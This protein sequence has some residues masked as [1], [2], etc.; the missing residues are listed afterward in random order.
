MGNSTS[1]IKNMLWRLVERFGAQLV[2]L[3][4]SII[5]AR[6]LDPEVY[7]TV[8]L[9][10]V[11][12]TIMQVFIDGGLGNALIQ[13]KNPDEL[14]YSSVFV[15]N[16]VMCLALYV[17]LFLFAPLIASFY[18]NDSLVLIIR[19]LGLTLIISGLKN[20]QQAYISKT[21]QFKKFFFATLLGTVGAAV[22]GITMALR[23]FGVWALVC[24][25]LFN[26]FIDTI[27]LRVSIKWTPK[28]KFSWK[29]M[30][31]LF[32]FG[33]KLLVSN[34]LEV[35]YNNLRQLIIGKKYSSAD[36]AYYNKA[37]Q[38][39]NLI[40]NNINIAID[41]VLLPTLSQEQESLTRVKTMTQKSIQMSGFILFP[42]LFGLAGSSRSLIGFLLTEK[43]LPSVP[44]MIVFC[45]YFS[46]FPIHTANLNAIKAV[47][48]SGVFLKL[49]IIK[50][51]IGIILLFITM[52]FGPLYM[53]LSLLIAGVLYVFINAYPNSKIIHYSV[54]EQIK[55]ILPSFIMSVVMGSVLF[56]IGFIPIPYFLLLII[57]VSVG[58]AI[59]LLLSVMT[60]N[61]NLMVLKQYISNYRHK[62]SKNNNNN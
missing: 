54:F 53:A 18:K 22:I 5:L 49:E 15:F 29:R 11:F 9:V 27:V 62:N 26:Q 37:L 55:D 12:M 30:K 56:G 24:Q 6:I 10:T 60:K 21:M 58:P 23:G 32:S 25:N 8:A 39:P 13:K 7:G 43:W 3:I 19:V 51:I 1:V 46:L 61:K 34:L 47:G 41:S 59:Y 28:I 38:W 2:S 42:L 16:L 20:I 52:P 44:Y 45:L 57:Q 17:L 4:V 31:S 35:V 33:W 14:D 48:K 50:K 36:L 40:V